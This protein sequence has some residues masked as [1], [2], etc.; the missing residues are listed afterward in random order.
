M[1]LFINSKVVTF[2]F[3]I[4]CV[5]VVVAPIVCGGRVSWFGNIV[6]CDL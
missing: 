1:Q 5:V 6:V 2:L 4:H 3:M